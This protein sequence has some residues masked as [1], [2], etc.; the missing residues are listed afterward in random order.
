VAEVLITPIR[1]ESG[2]VCNHVILVR[3]VTHETR[4]ERRL[5]QAEKLEAIGVLA[6]GI[7]HDFNNI[8]TPILLNAEVALGDLGPDDPLR[9]PLADVV[10][11]AGR[12]RDLV[13]QILTF[14]RREDRERAFWSSTPWSRRRSSSCAA[15]WTRTSP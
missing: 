10:D 11:A 9:R 12:A 4:L 1:D 14:S 6:G 8:L 13:K 2:K 5:R 7:A 15:W 3:D